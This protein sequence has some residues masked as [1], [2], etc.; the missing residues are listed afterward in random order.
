MIDYVRI[1]A[2]GGPGGS[3]CVSF[4][5][6]KYV[7][8]GGPD[9]GDGG[10]GGNVVVVAEASVSTLRE[11]GRK[12][13]Y[14]AE[15]GE[16][17]KGSGR[18]GRRGRDVVLRVPVGTEVRLP[19]E[20]LILEDLDEVGKSVVVAR[21]GLGG[22]GNAW[23][24]R[25]EYQAP[26]I[27]Q[28]GQSGEDREV[29]LDLKVLADVGIVG[30]P[31][32]GKSTL[33]RAVSAARPR[34]ADYPFT[35]REPVLGVVEVGVGRFVIADIPGVIEGAHRG[36]GLGLEFLRHIER[37]R[38]LV[39]MLDGTRPDPISD[40]DVVNGELSE[41]S[42][43]LAERQ[44]FVVVNKVDL[45]AV[46]NRVGELAE[47]LARRGI[48]GQF[49]SAVECRG[50]DELVRRIGEVLRHERDQGTQA[51][52]AVVRP[53]PVGRQFRVERE[54]DGFRVRGERVVTFA[55]MMPVEME[56]GRQELWWRLGRWGVTA[57]VRRAGAR[58]GARVRLGRVELEWPG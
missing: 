42:G 29:E 23:F 3:G 51:R 26:R 49:I 53:K 50:T 25:A 32:V 15:K 47:A 12:R 27:A 21:G 58:P 57:A 46:E 56:E 7:P 9:G 43:A 37:T 31:N 34:V 17:G 36:A 22:K 33:L 10:R 24:A 28:R 38:I 30:L 20:G 14:R 39:H 19:E 1:R 48:E 13:V 44:Q 35:T 2:M 54:D 4:R 6:E 16:H 52:P 45:A 40:M 5:R 8:R 55:E 41:Y 11:L 18:N